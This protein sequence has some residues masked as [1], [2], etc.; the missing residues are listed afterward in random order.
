MWSVVCKIMTARPC[1]ILFRN[2][3]S[4][5]QESDCHDPCENMGVS[6]AVPFLLW[7][8]GI[9]GEGLMSNGEHGAILGFWGDMSG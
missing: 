2:K 8:S 3:V 1:L 9:C 4:G 5:E 7:S 6:W